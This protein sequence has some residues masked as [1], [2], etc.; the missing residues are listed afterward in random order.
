MAANRA[1][2]QVEQGYNLEFSRAL[3]ELELDGVTGGSLDDAVLYGSEDPEETVKVKSVLEVGLFDEN[4]NLRPIEWTTVAASLEVQRKM[5]PGFY[6]RYPTDGQVIPGL[7]GNQRI[8]FANNKAFVFPKQAGLTLTIGMEVY[9]Y[10]ED[11]A[12]AALEPTPTEDIWT[13]NA[14]DY[15][16]WATVVQLNYRFKEFVPRQEGNMATPESMRDAALQR[17]LEWDVNQFELWRRHQ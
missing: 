15:L 8:T 16:L 6:P 11:W 13:T 4:G 1:R 3:V 14:A 17:F 12:A 7:C 10:A 2:R 5:K 9:T